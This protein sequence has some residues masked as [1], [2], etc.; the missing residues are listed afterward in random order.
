[1][2]SI[3]LYMFYIT[4]GYVFPWR[5]FKNS[6]VGIKENSL[7]LNKRMV[8]MEE[9]QK[10]PSSTRGCRSQ[11][12]EYLNKREI[13]ILELLNCGLERAEIAQKLSISNHLSGFKDATDRKNR[14]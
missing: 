2:A 5:Y 14:D 11:D 13:K 8:I 3:L 4:L 10:D 6:Y 7:K 9:E 12:E 1:M